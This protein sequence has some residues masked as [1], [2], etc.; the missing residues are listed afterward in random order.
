MKEIILVVWIL[1]GSM[2]DK[3]DV[4]NSFRGLPV[5]VQVRTSEKLLDNQIRKHNCVCGPLWCKGFLGNKRHMFLTRPVF[6]TNQFIFNDSCTGAEVFTRSKKDVR[7]V[8]LKLVRG[9]KR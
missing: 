4:I 1:S 7:N 6:K 9:C 3:S 5:K 2:L 8:A